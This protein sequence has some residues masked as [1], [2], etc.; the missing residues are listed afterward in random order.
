MS[1][2]ATKTTKVTRLKIDGTNYRKAA[3]TTDTLVSDAVDMQGFESVEAFLLVGALTA[4]AVTDLRAKQCDTVGGTYADLAGT[5]VSLTAVTDD[6]K[7]AHLEIVQPRE[8]FVKFETNRATANAV[9][10]G[11]LVI[12]HRAKEMPVADDATTIVGSE[13]HA[14]PAEGTA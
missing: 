6:N 4:T 11:L 3:G 9:L 14:S 5:K 10:D 2:H 12:Q 7:V 13:V 8:R 1:L